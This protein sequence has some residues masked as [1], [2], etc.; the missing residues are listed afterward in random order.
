MSW[1]E[2]IKIN[3]DMTVSLDKLIKSAK[4]E[5]IDL[6]NSQRSL[7]ASDSVMKVISSTEVKVNNDER[8]KEIGRFTCHKNGSVR[9]K[10]DMRARSGGSYTTVARFYVT[11]LS[12][13]IIFEESIRSSE[14]QD[15]VNRSKDIS[16]KPDTTYIIY[17]EL[18]STN[19]DGYFNNVNVCATVID[20][21]FIS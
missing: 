14:T 20:A 5:L 3:S 12:G 17:G 16:V 6:I 21:S 18:K 2:T 11:D 19:G 4:S 13:G 10:W 15:W 7:G 8:T 9:I 1:S